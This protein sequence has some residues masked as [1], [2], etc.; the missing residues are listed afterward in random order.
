MSPRISSSPLH[1]LFI[2]WSKK[3]WSSLSNLRRV[4]SHLCCKRFRTNQS[5]MVPIKYLNWLPWIKT[6]TQLNGFL[7]LLH[8]PRSQLLESLVVLKLIHFEEREKRHPWVE[9]HWELPFKRHVIRRRWGTPSPLLSSTTLTFFP[10][11]ISSS[12]PNTCRV[13]SALLERHSHIEKPERSKQTPRLGCSRVNEGSL[14]LFLQWVT[15]WCE[16]KWHRRGPL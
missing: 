5:I 9:N 7:G 12:T 14:L 10:P 3:K 2:L 1:F 13:N 11:A 16:R 8:K 6:T 15:L 4:L